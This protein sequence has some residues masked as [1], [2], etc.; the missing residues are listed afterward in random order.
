MFIN[1]WILFADLVEEFARRITQKSG[2]DRLSEDVRRILWPSKNALEFGL[3]LAN[4]LVVHGDLTQDFGA[5]KLG[6]QDILLISLTGRIVRFCLLLYLLQQ[7]GV[8]LKCS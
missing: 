8:P 3:V 1:V 4:Q 7:R 2:R 5:L 6:L